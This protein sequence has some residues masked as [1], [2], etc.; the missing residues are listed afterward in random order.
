MRDDTLSFAP[1]APSGINISRILRPSREPE[2]T[3]INLRP[4]A[5]IRMV[6]LR[7]ITEPCGARLISS[8]IARLT[9]C[10]SIQCP[11]GVYSRRHPISL[12]QGDLHNNFSFAEV[13]KRRT[14]ILERSGVHYASSEAPRTLSQSHAVRQSWKGVE[15]G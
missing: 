5:S 12:H 2:E 15:R 3:P 13:R 4:I 1:D 6:L 9:E 7:L 8:E 11:L 14:T 10:Q